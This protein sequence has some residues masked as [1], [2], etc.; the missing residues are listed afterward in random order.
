MRSRVQ[1]A[2]ERLWYRDRGAPPYFFDLLLAPFL[3][4]A[5]LAY[6]AIASLRRFAYRT[7]LFH[8]HRLD[9]PVV[10]VGSLVV[11]GVGKTQVVIAIAERLAEMGHRPVVVLRG[12]K[13]RAS[14]RGAIVSEGKGG[15]PILASR[16]AGDEAV[17]IAKRLPNVAVSIGADRVRAARRAVTLLGADVVVLDDGFQHVR[18]ARTLDIVVWDAGVATRT[19]HL[20]PYGPFRE[21]VSAVARADLLVTVGQNPAVEPVAPRPSRALPLVAFT[22]VVEFRKLDGETIAAPTETVSLL[23]TLASPSRVVATL[24]SAGVSVLHHTVLPDH[25]VPRAIDVALL[26]A[27]PIVMT[28]KDATKITPD[29]PR[30]G[31]MIVVRAGVSFL[32]SSGATLRN[33]LAS[34]FEKQR[35]DPLRNAAN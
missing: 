35:N 31:D 32:G 9:V 19:L 7:G 8:V 2:F 25:A 23:T 4:A 12:Y 1:S 34:L 28:E 6:R 26:P 18:L 20:L 27:G 3:L 15:P 24:R 14:R 16:D 33:R 11:G 22:K 29:F 21:P 13:G 10:S 17:E 30:R 5:S